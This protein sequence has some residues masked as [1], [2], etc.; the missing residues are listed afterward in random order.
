VFEPGELHT[1]TFT[2]SQGWTVVR[3]THVP[4]GESVERERTKALRSSVQAQRECIDELGDRIETSGALRSTSPV[5]DPT[6]SRQEF[7]E[8]VARVRAVEQR[9]R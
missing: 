2:N 5:T 4:S 9:L 3:V 1:E 8:L 6:V 7:D